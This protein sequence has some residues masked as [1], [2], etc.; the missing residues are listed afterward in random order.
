[1]LSNQEDHTRV[2]VWLFWFELEFD[3]YVH[4]RQNEHRENKLQINSNG[5]KLKALFESAA[6]VAAL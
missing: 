2:S 6:V 5:L 3:Y 4:T 1:M